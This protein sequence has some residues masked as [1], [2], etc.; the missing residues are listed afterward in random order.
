[1]CTFASEISFAP[2]RSTMGTVDVEQTVEEVLRSDNILWDG[3][4][5]SYDQYGRNNSGGCNPNHR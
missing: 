5:P 4:T 3:E 1:M 2:K